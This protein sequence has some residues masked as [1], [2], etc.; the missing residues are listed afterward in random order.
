[1]ALLPKISIGPVSCSPH[2]IAQLLDDVRL[3]LRDKSD[4]PRTILCVNA[5]I[6]NLAFK[7]AALRQC[8]NNARINAADGKAICWAARV[9]GGNIPE[10]CNMTEAFRAF[11]QDTHMPSTTAILVGMTE[12]E[13]EAAAGNINAA[14][15]HCKIVHNSCGFLDDADYT[16]IF[17]QHSSADFIFLGMSTPRTELTTQLAASICPNA[18]VWGIG[19]GTIRIYAG[20]MQEAPAWMRRIGLQWLHRLFSDPRKLW[21]RYIIGN[22]KFVLHVLRARFGKSP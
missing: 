19:A 8:L 22:P 2:T 14:Q 21:K 11:L 15:T 10:R 9:F 13:C 1:M 12:P 17:R 5:H 20:T 6:Y 16:K 7:D 4:Q 3:L 18:I